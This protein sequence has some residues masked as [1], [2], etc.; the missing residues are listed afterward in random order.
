MKTIQ[1]VIEERLL[2]AADREVKRTK[3]SRSKLFREA[4][5]EHLRRIRIREAEEREARAYGA[6]PAD[7]FD[8]WDRVD[9]WPE[10]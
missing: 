5:A 3:T 7:E 9:Q 6:K 8:V 2:R 1:I 10:E 4:V